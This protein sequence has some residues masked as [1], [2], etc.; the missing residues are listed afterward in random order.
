MSRSRIK[1]ACFGWPNEREFR[2]SLSHLERNAPPLIHKTFADMQPPPSERICSVADGFVFLNFASVS[3]LPA[4]LPSK[5]PDH[6]RDS[7]WG[8]IFEMDFPNSEKVP[9]PFPW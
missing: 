4:M 7:F 3:L 5:I 6:F 8:N 9:A 2:D 1:D